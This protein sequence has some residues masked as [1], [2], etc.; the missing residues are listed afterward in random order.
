MVVLGIDLGTKNICV[1][2]P[3][4]HSFGIV[5]NREA[6]RL[7]DGI[8]GFTEQDGRLFGS[9]ARSRQKRNIRNTIYELIRLIGRKWTDQDLGRDA[10]WWGFYLVKNPHSADTIAVEVTHNNQRY[11]LGAEQILAAY[12]SYLRDLAISDL[13]TKDVRDCCVAVP[14]YFT[15]M[16]RKMVANACKIAGMN[17][18][19]IV[20]STTAVALMW[21]LNPMDS[22]L[23]SQCVMFV[24]VGYANTQVGVAE[25]VTEQKSMQMICHTSNRNAGGRDID[26]AMVEHFVSQVNLKYGTNILSDKNPNWKVINRLSQACDKLKKKLGLN[27][28]AS[29]TIDCLIEGDD[30]TIRMNRD[31]LHELMEP[32][33]SR[34]L[35]PIKDALFQ[36]NSKLSVKSNEAKFTCVELVGGGLRVPI[37]KQKIEETIQHAKKDIPN[38]ENCIVR[39]TMNGDECI[40]KGTAYLATMLS[41]SY[42]VREMKFCD[43]TNFDIHVVSGAEAKKLIPVDL[44]QIPL[45]DLINRPI[46]RRGSKTKSTRNLA[47]DMKQAEQLIRTP[48]KSAE[49]HSDL[50]E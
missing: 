10:M 8:L 42:K 22:G 29:I 17:L 46:W 47:L 27:N 38:M 41:K 25:Y 9:F 16:Q 21:G 1:A 26:R 44:P 20:N 28:E 39:K 45:I 48:K 12:I 43:M 11:V 33:L 24:D 30:Y 49:L 2:T 13:R 19:R 36:L 34:M 50:S 6:K 37:I 4:A 35:Q 23:K 40:S 14:N 31:Q 5:L 3:K 32:I 18:L 7:N 15:H